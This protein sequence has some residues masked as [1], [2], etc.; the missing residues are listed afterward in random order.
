VSAEDST[1]YGIFERLHGETGDV[2]SLRMKM[3]AIYPDRLNPGLLP[4][5]AAMTQG[6]VS[7]KDV[8]PPTSTED[9]DLSGST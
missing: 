7:L 5:S 2:E 4:E 6:A 3:L 9:E 1:I 8:L